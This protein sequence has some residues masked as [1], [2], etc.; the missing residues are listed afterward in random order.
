M[1]KRFIA[2]AVPV[3]VAGSLAA[4]APSMSQAPP[5]TT[6][7][8]PRRS[9]EAA[10]RGEVA[11]CTGGRRRRPSRAV[12]PTG[13]RP[14]SS[15]IVP[16]TLIQFRGPELGQGHRVRHAHRAHTYVSDTSDVGRVRV[17]LDGVDMKPATG[18]A[19]YFYSANNYGSFAGQYCGK[20][21]PGFHKVRVVLGVPRLGRLRR[22]HRLPLQPDGPRRGRQL[23]TH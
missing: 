1:K 15:T 10:R 13:S 11:P 16:G 7:R 20:V 17:L 23:T 14:N 3:L 19:E 22:R 4:A 6:G 9:G 2:A 18:A 12:T 5:A 8:R 21:G